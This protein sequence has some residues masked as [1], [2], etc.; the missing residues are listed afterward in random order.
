MPK[1]AGYYPVTTTISGTR[2][3]YKIRHPTEILYIED[4]RT[5][6]GSHL[7]LAVVP[8]DY[9]RP[10]PITLP[11]TTAPTHPQRYL[12]WSSDEPGASIFSFR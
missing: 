5:T 4:D 7:D 11:P 9:G 3:F 2:Q 6:D 1:G 10:L 8:S 12:S